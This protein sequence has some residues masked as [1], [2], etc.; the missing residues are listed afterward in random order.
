MDYKKKKREERLNMKLF[1]PSLHLSGQFI[2]RW[3]GKEKKA[4]SLAGRE[5]EKINM[6]RCRN[7]VEGRRAD[8]KVRS[9]YAL[10]DSMFIDNSTNRGRLEVGLSNGDGL[11]ITMSDTD[12][13]LLDTGLLSSGSGIA[14]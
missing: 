5:K 9:D 6:N 13:H 14:M 7:H 1:A 12:M 2:T 11:S 8:P 10:E 3:H 4:E